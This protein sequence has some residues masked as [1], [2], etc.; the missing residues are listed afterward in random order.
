MFKTLKIAWYLDKLKRNADGD[1]FISWSPI[2]RRWSI[3]Y[4]GELPNQYVCGKDIE[5]VLKY[6][7]DRKIIK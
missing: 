6:F 4:E 5:S 1:F 2:I 3:G 7:L